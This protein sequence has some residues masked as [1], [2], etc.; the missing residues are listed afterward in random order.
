MGLDREIRRHATPTAMQ[1]QSSFHAEMISTGNYA[2]LG[3]LYD[4]PLPMMI[5]GTYR[6][7]RSEPEVWGF[8]QTL[9]AA[10]LAAGSQRL[11]AIVTQ[12]E[13]AREGRFRVWTDWYGDG[14]L[15]QTGRIAETLCYY[16]GTGADPLVEM[17]EFLKL[18]LPGFVE[19]LGAGGADAED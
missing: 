10:L 14:P 16:S 4:Y 2:A 9:H 15:G 12:E 13:S 1:L 11:T 3:K 8:Y 17:V 6:V 19:T 7:V 5:G 18:D